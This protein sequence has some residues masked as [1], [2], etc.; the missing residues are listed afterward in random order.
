M[1]GG[2]STA[3]K[4]EWNKRAY[5]QYMIR[6]RKDTPLYDRI[7][8]FRGKD[9]TNM[10]RLMTKLLEDFFDSREFEEIN[11]GPDCEGKERL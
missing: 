5:G 9:G 2:T 3:A 1:C 7:E 4:T 8:A 6:V 10:N 11:A